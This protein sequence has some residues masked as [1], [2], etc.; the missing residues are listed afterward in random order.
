[1]RSTVQAFVVTFLVVADM[2]VLFGCYIVNSATF[3][4]R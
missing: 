3:E 1:M 4:I 2:S